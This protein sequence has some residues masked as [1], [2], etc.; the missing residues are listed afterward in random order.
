MTVEADERGRLYLAS[1]VRER[2]GERFHLVEYQN[3]IELI[4]VDGDP[5]EGL[6]EAVGD[7]FEGESVDELRDRARAKAREEARVDVRRD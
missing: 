6:R 2:H 1:D 4:P 7:A 5:L 3:R